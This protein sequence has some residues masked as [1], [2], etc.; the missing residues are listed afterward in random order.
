M[1]RKPEDRLERIVNDLLKGRRLKLRGGDAEDKD[2]ITTAA[3]LAGTRQGPQRMQSAFRKQLA[4]KLARTPQEGWVTR[5]AA[6]VAGLGLAAG[7]AGGIL[8]GRNDG[9]ET[10][11]GGGVAIDPVNGRWVDVAA[12]SDLVEGQ[13]KHVVA[14]SVS[15]FV[16]RRG[17]SV[18]AVS[19]ICS[20]LP[21][22]LWW[23]KRAAVLQC[24]CHPVSFAADGR[25]GDGY[26]MPSLSK[27]HVRVTSAG[28]VEVLGTE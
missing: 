21:C 7:A 15:A 25:P 3:R 24:P 19:A 26:H 5:R 22:E 20:H 28:R 2:A 4:E 18:S 27:V 23:D 11:A 8:L 17:D 9:V 14:G 13:G 1:G 6:L 12:M 10:S 16:F